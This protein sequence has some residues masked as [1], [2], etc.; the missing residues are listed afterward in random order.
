MWPSSFAAEQVDER[1]RVAAE[2]NERFQEGLLV[3]LL[4]T[5]PGGTEGSGFDKKI[6]QLL[7]LRHGRQSKEE[8]YN[9]LPWQLE[10]WPRCKDHSSGKGI[11]GNWFTSASLVSRRLAEP[12]RESESGTALYGCNR[13][14]CGRT[15]ESHKVLADAGTNQA[16]EFT[17][18]AEEWKGAP[19]FSSRCLGTPDDCTFR[20]AGGDF[21]EDN[22][23]VWRVDQKFLSQ[24]LHFSGRFDP[25]SPG[26]Q[27]FAEEQ[28][29]FN[30]KPSRQQF[31]A[32]EKIHTMGYNEI[33]VQV[34]TPSML[35]EEMRK[36][37][38]VQ[39]R[40]SI[41]QLRLWQCR[42][43]GVAAFARVKLPPTE[44]DEHTRQV[45]NCRWEVFRK[46]RDAYDVACGRAE[47]TPI[48]Y[49]D[50]SAFEKPFSAPDVQELFPSQER[51]N[52]S[53]AQPE[54]GE[55]F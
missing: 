30:P 34:G 1:R 25:Q 51:C 2:L 38:V 18:C 12:S 42:T 16:G 47:P 37:G 49:F 13:Y 27:L 4:A 10:E 21:G 43:N 24:K 53:L 6:A 32:G 5:S 45:E 9:P 40:F 48:L 23:G 26:A 8:G 46:M 35:F 31:E 17:G 15:M 11:A 7:G 3:K 14:A 44:L 55:T 33:M 39:K 29:R 20:R 22:R 50:M 36:E 19:G 52:S 28:R 41:N 54:K